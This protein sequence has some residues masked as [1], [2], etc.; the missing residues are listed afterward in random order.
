MTCARLPFRPLKLFLDRAH[1]NASGAM[2]K[3]FRLP[4][5]SPRIGRS[6]GKG[7]PLPMAL[8]GVLDDVRRPRA[9]PG[10]DFHLS[11]AKR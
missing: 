4:V 1:S 11:A 10:E 8:N 6:T 9:Q 5:V 3:R 2:G 7:E